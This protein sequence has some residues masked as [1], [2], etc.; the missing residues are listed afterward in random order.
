MKELLGRRLDRLA[1]GLDLDLRDRFDRDSDALLRVEVL[2]GRDVEG[3]ELERKL[4]AALDHR[5]NDRAV[6][7]DDPRPAEPVHDERLVGPR[8]PEHLGQQDQDEQEGE[9]HQP[10]DDPRPHCEPEHNGLLE[11]YL[12]K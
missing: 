1:V 10:Q 6:P 7:L 11:S 2:L 9:S 5:K 3:H 8:L 12:M 4:A